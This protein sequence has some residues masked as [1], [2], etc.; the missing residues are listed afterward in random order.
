MKKVFITGIAGFIGSHVADKFYDSGWKVFGID[1]LS[2]GNFSNIKCGAK[3]DIADIRN[4]YPDL[5][6]VIGGLDAFVHLAAQPSLLESQNNPHKDASINIMGTL[7]AIQLSQLYGAKHF[8]FSSTSAIYDPVQKLPIKENGQ[9]YPDSNYG[10]SK[11]SA[12]YYVRSAGGTIFR[13]GNVYGPRQV[14]VGENQLVPRLLSHIYHG[15][16][17]SIYG[18]GEQLRDYIYVTDV[19]DAIFRA[20]LAGISGTFNLGTMTGTRTKDIVNMVVEMT[21]HDGEIRRTEARDTRN[22]ILD[23]S[24]FS[25]FWRP[26]VTLREGL[27]ITIKEWVNESIH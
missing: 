1:D 14:P 11:L 5:L 7:N 22:V 25:E 6:D 27:A 13:F 24:K 3:W 21:Q 8:V 15:T 26:S 16:P 9:I 19:A 17:F 18:S 20:C 2:S 10:I 4:W 12:E 23:T